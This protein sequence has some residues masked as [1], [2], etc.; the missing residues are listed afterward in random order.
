MEK[1]KLGNNKNNRT[2]QVRTGIRSGDACRDCSKSCYCDY[3]DHQD[4]RILDD[5]IFDHCRNVC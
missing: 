5:C 2:L 1:V 4:K 3:Y